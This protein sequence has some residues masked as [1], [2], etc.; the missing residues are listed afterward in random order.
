MST[1][2]LWIEGSFRPSA[3]G[4]AGFQ[5]WNPVTGRPISG[6]YPISGR[7]DLEA[8]LAA[9][10]R[11]APILAEAPPDAIARFLEEYATRIESHAV[12]LSGLAHEETA[13]PVRPRLFEVE[14][15]RT[16]KQLR[17]GARIARSRNWREP[18]IDTAANLR[19]Q[20]GP[21]GKPVVIFGPNNFP[22][23]FNA[24]SGSD[25]VSAWVAQNPVLAK[26]HPGHPHL[27]EALAHLAQDSLDV[28]G[29]P[30]GSIQLCY[31]LEESSGFALAGDSRVGAVCFTGSRPAGL[32]LKAHADSAGIPFFGEMSSTN[33]VFILP[34][35]LDERGEALA[36]E[37]ATSCLLGSGQFCTKPGL[38]VLPSGPPAETWIG[39][40]TGLFA[41]APTAVLLAA[42][43]RDRFEAALARWA[44]AGARRLTALRPIAEAGFRA[45]PALF[46][47]DVQ[48]FLAHRT[49]L[50][51]EAF[52][53]AALVLFGVDPTEMPHLAAG[54][55]GQLT[56]TLLSAHNG[57]DEVF[58]APLATVL[59]MRAGRLLNDKMPTGVQVSP[60]MNHGGPFP[61]TNQPGFTSVGL[62]GAIR[63]LS[64]LYCYD[65]IRPARLPA[66]LA[67]SN[68]VPG[69][70][71][72]IDGTWTTGDID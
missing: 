12:A 15:P 30:P 53:P 28:A 50:E 41:T 63:R 38:I 8:F 69:L 47:V 16:V 13:L 6:E 52:G 66:E 4:G 26:G 36:T 18:V 67:N 61:A 58:Y 42:G 51:T 29:L 65:G 2:P 59:R 72:L 64:A 17:E 14:L 35:A 60:A 40:L 37:I 39:T 45:Q 55:E 21:L 49:E 9:A 22:F 48:T 23:A 62:P 71:R 7:C 5:A 44:E 3:D 19:A 70:W 20:R 68:P 11:A 24:L 46:S 57:A 27:T 1:A 10:T 43:V 31:G 54:L 34:G 25:F 32:A 33:P 56:A